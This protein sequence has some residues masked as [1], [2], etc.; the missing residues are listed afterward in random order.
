MKK[1]EQ[2]LRENEISQPRTPEEY[3]SWFEEKLKIIKEHSELREQIILHKGISKYFHEELFPLYRLLQNKRESWESVKLIP[4]KGNQNYDVELKSVREDI[5]KFIEITTI[6]RN[7][8]EHARMEYFLEHGHVDLLG[9]VAIDRNK[10]TGRK[11]VVGEGFFS[12]EE[13]NQSVK[14]RIEKAIDKKIKIAKRPDHT[15]LLIYFDDYVSFR[16][17]KNTSKSEMSSY[18]DSLN[19]NW[20]D[21]YSVLYVVGTSGNSFWER[22]D[23]LMWLAKLDNDIIQAFHHLDLFKKFGEIIDN[24]ET[25]KTMDNTLLVWMRTAFSVDLVISMGRICDRDKRTDS[26]VRFLEDLKEKNNLLRRERY[27]GL[28]KDGNFVRASSADK[29]FGKDFFANKGFDSLAGEGREYYS[30]D[31]IKAD[32]KKITESEPI[33]KI[34]TYRNQYIAHSD[35]AKDESPSYTELF[36]AFEIIEKIVKRYNL[37][38]RAASFHKFTPVMQ[39]D[40]QEVFTVP[41][42]KREVLS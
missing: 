6:E 2:Y 21:K 33:R 14:N 35:R 3:I 20:Q 11:I 40:W 1:L 26:L 8:K 23:T 41:W 32:I 10:A 22:L 34:L 42:I 31:L 30:P 25:L 18:L 5:P 39:G 17:D 27:L 37:L 24:N 13:I 19:K 15:A 4:V 7:E 12:E 38:L 36:Q 29:D 28:W 16:Y 9:E